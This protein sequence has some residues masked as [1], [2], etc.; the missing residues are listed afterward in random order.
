[1]MLCLLAIIRILGRGRHASKTHSYAESHRQRLGR[2]RATRLRSDSASSPSFRPS[3]SRW[4]RISS[5]P[6]PPARNSTRW[7]PRSPTPPVS[8]E[9]SHLPGRADARPGLASNARPPASL[10]S[11]SPPPRRSTSRTSTSW[12]TR[13]GPPAGSCANTR[14]CS[15]RR[16]WPRR[17][18]SSRSRRFVRARRPRRGRRRGQP[19]RQPRRRRAAPA[20]ENYTVKRGDTLSKIA[21]DVKPPAVSLE[22]MLVA[23]FKSNADAFDGNNMN[24]LRTGAILTMPSAEEAAATPATE[25]TKTV[26][27]QAADWRALSRS[28]RAPRRWPKAPADAR[29]PADRHRG[30]GKDARRRRPGGD[31]LACRASRRGQGRGRRRGNGRAR[32]SS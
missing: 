31:Q 17:R 18:R 6:R 2:C 25:A 4:S 5:S 30:R 15:I 20:G 1:M 14:S 32:Q 16:A 21:G 13:T 7:P 27:V 23:L 24:R 28:R 10:S 26:R 8:R 12:S 9:Q 22:Q 29:P 11:R 3:G 19:R